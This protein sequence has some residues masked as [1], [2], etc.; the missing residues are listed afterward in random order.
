MRVRHL[1]SVAKGLT[2]ALDRGH[3]VPVDGVMDRAREPGLLDDLESDY[4]ID[5]SFLDSETR[6]EIESAWHS[7]SNAYLAEDL[8]VSNNGLALLLAWTL[9]V[10]DSGVEAFSDEDVV[11]DTF[12]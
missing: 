8:G 11:T 3:H 1:L 10:V 7:L 12:A 2:T 5:L 4:E 6:R 9:S